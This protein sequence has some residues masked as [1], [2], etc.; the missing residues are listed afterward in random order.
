MMALNEFFPTLPGYT[1]APASSP[2]A[3]IELNSPTAQ[4]YSIDQLQHCWALLVKLYTGKDN[5]SFVYARTAVHSDD[6][7]INTTHARIISYQ[8]QTSDNRMGIDMVYRGWKTADLSSCEQS[9]VNTAVLLHTGIVG[10]RSGDV[11]SRDWTGDINTK[12]IEHTSLRIVSS[13]ASGSLVMQYRPNC[14]PLRYAESIARTFERILDDYNQPT[15]TSTHKLTRLQSLA[16]DST[17]EYLLHWGI[18]GG[19]RTDSTHTINTLVRASVQATPDAEAICA[20]D[21]RLSYRQLDTLSDTLAMRLISAG[22]VKGT[23]VAYAFTKS[24]WAVVAILGILKAGGVFAAL[25]PLQSKKRLRNMLRILGCTTLVTSDLHASEVSCLVANSLV[26]PRD[27]LSSG[28]TS[29][30]RQEIALESTDAAFVL[31][32]SGSTGYPKAILHEHGAVCSH[33]LALG[34]AMGYKGARVLQFSAYIWDVAVIDILITL[35]FGGSVCIPSEEDRLHDISA[36]IQWSKANL[37]LLTPSYARSIDPDSVSSLK[38]LALGGE[39]M[40][41][42]DVNRWN[43]R[44]TLMNVYG[45]AEVGACSL[46]TSVTA[47]ATGE[48]EGYVGVKNIGRP[49]RNSPCWLIDPD[50]VNV[51]VPVGSVGELV[52]SGINLAREY[53][54]QRELTATSFVNDPAWAEA[55]EL[56]GPRRFYRTGDL[57]SYD[58]SAFDGSLLFMGRKD[59]QMKVR[60]QRIEPGEIEY[61]LS[62]VPDV[63]GGIVTIPACGPWEGELVALVTTNQLQNHGHLHSDPLQALPAEILPLSRIQ[64]YLSEFLPGYMIPTVCVALAHFPLTASMKINRKEVKAWLEKME[65]TPVNALQSQRSS[66]AAALAKTEHTAV[67]ISSL[68]SEYLRSLHPD[69]PV[70]LEALDHDVSLHSAGLDSIQMITFFSTLRKRFGNVLSF[71]AVM[72]TRQLTVR[73]LARIID[74]SGGAAPTRSLFFV[75]V[76]AEID[77]ISQQLLRRLDSL[78]VE[79]NDN[80]KSKAAAPAIQ[81]VFLTG[82]SGYLGRHIFRQLLC[83]PS[84]HIYILARQPSPSGNTRGQRSPTPR[85]PI[86]KTAMLEGWWD[87]SFRQRYTVWS[88]DL[89][90]KDLGLSKYHLALLA[91][92][93]P[94]EKVVHGIIHC[95]AVVHYTLDYESLQAANVH[96]TMN[97]LEIMARPRSPSSFVFIS[98]GRNPTPTPTTALTATQNQKDLVRDKVEV[99]RVLWNGYSQSKYISERLTLEAHTLPVPYFQGKH[100]CTVNPGYIIGSA[101]N[102]WCANTRDF[103]WKLVAGC[104][105]IGLYNCDEA[106]GWLFVSDVAS[107]SRVAVTALLN[108]NQDSGEDTHTH[109]ITEGLPFQTLWDIL[110]H[111]YGYRLSGVSGEQWLQTLKSAVLDAGEAHPLFTLLPM[112]ETNGLGLGTRRDFL[113]SV[114]DGVTECIRRNIAYLVRIGFL[115]RQPS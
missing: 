49:L 5:V 40:T 65:N 18:K 39:C 28:S 67:I 89:A 76:E 8:Y 106:D 77:D 25:D 44:L 98:G 51:L 115:P 82:A 56:K 50:D 35:I 85:D 88:G 63:K 46:N 11:L 14:I 9:R 19:K 110:Q 45:P 83:Q 34:D 78:T 114:S 24:S 111:E 66:N 68:L 55:L 86:S 48:G 60:G 21:G 113:L 72:K 102:N 74:G 61:H 93:G 6:A 22:V 75:N 100:L 84:V 26:L 70:W 103:I 69:R 97:L 81:N 59:D 99:D 3:V 33:A 54:D 38:T 41:K 91:G 10:K 92:Q 47:V 64:D 30:P 108:P 57:A 15:F 17:R 36:F 2:L 27:A 73:S 109:A 29:R 79:V 31:F 87:E 43:G 101:T 90:E 112:L 42:E 52:V 1:P 16:L 62:H 80:K 94:A 7:L 96:S 20:W 104:L 107:V 12:E 105:E 71:P 37:A 53:L 23:R 32:T 95:G 58:I 13:L 4:R